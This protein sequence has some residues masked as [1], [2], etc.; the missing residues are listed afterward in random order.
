MTP[1]QEARFW[2]Y[3]DKSGD[4]WLWTGRKHM[5]GYGEFSARGPGRRTTRYAHRAAWEL[6]YGSI[7]DGL[8]VCHKC[9]VRACCNP[10]HLFLGTQKDNLADCKLKG[11]TSHGAAHYNAV[12]NAEI[13]AAV[14]TQYARGN[15][16]YRMLALEYGIAAATIRSAIHGKSWTHI[17]DPPALPTRTQQVAA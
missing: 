14:R 1:E 13:V 16:S 11:R 7:P 8:Y 5:R 6:T 2:S 9:D 10:N 3:V 12:L 4:C 15:T 17:T